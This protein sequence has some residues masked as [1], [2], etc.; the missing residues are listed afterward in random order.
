[1]SRAVP[2]HPSAIISEEAELAEGVV[3]GPFAVIEAGVRI[4]KDCMVGAHAH[5]MGDVS[6]GE[7]SRIGRSAV[8]GEEPQDLSF[9]SR[10]RSGVRVGRNNVIRE[11]ATIHRSATEG[12][13]TRIGDDNFLMVGAHL[14][15]DV[16]MGDGNVLANNVLLAGH[17]RVGSNVFLGGG[18]VVHQFIR[19]GDHCLTQGNSAISKDVPPYVIA[20]RLNR[21]G[22]MNVVGLRR[23]GFDRE[24]RIEIRR[25]IEQLFRSGLPLRT[26][27][28]EARK[29][30]WGE[31]A[32][33]L[34]E[35]V[36]GQSSKGVLTA[37][38]G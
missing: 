22:G 33:K 23:A 30:T 34:I 1:M 6:L 21:F 31:E 9:S 12:G 36:E 32:T 5:L 4:G 3:V 17:V 2:I 18:T 20:F 29:N 19:L 35:F 15:H 26:A 24:T 37:K 16:E 7:G 8:I 13:M 10:I 38:G 27:L 14:A 11:H 28:K 25:A